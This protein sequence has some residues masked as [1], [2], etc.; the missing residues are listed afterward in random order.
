VEK[1]CVQC[2]RR[3]EEEETRC[4]E[5][6]AALAD[7][8]VGDPRVGTLVADGRFLLLGVLGRGGMGSVYRARQRS[9][10][11]DVAIKILSREDAADPE[12]AA[13]FTHEAKSLGELRSRHIVTVYDFGE[14]DTGELFIAMELLS[15]RPLDDLIRDEGPVPPA[16]ALP[17]LDQ[18]A[19]ALDEA[20]HLGIIHRDMKPAN[21]IVEHER[22]GEDVAKVLDFGLVKRLGP[23]GA[24]LELTQQGALYG[25]PAFMAP[26]MWSEKHGPIGPWTDVYAFGALAHELLT[27]RRAFVATSIAGY[28]EQHLR[29]PPPSLGA[30]LS[31]TDLDGIVRRCLAKSPPERYQSIAELRVDL[32]RASVVPERKSPERAEPETRTSMVTISKI[33]FGAACAALLFLFMRPAE[34]ARDGAPSGGAT[35]AATSSTATPLGGESAESIAESVST[36]IAQT[37][38][39]P[40]ALVTSRILGPLRSEDVNRVLA[41]LKEP[42]ARCLRNRPTSGPDD[43]P[44]RLHIVVLPDGRIASITA[45]KDARGRALE[46][47]A[48]A[49]AL[50]SARFPSFSNALLA[51]VTAEL[52]PG[53]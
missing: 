25:T 20:H 53:R 6:G 49:H 29:S 48:Q 4:S 52:D 30:D 41:E 43:K 35:R 22:T 9:M 32:G 50:K 15:G 16:R 11:R 5:D 26:E 27:G 8:A 19:S 46:A 23:A 45:P 36:N 3:F 1:I 24:G 28:L 7:L 38:A 47:C 51:T 18:I 42:L 40:P 31:G 13:R 34:P 12:F 17:M 2:L 10:G 21:V 33:V 39:R 37:G 44:M 14:L